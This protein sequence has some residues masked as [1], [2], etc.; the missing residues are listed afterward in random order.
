M[1]CT[2]CG[3]PLETN[4]RFCRN[5]GQLSPVMPMQEG[6]TES[7]PTN[8]ME[9]GQALPA[10]P[11]IFPQSQTPYYQPA[12][13][14]LQPTQPVTPGTMPSRAQDAL[15]R[16]LS[17]TGKTSR[18]G[19]GCITGCLV[20]LLVLVV[21]VGAGWVFALRPFLHSLAQA[22][23]DQTLTNAVNQIPAQAAQL[24]PGT[25]QVHENA[26]NNLIVLNSSPSDPVQQ[27]QVHIMPGGVRLNFQVYGFPCA[28][29]GVPQV[30]NGPL[31]GRLVITNVTVEG[32]VALIMS[33]GE[34]TNLANRHLAD[35]Q[36][37]FKH[38]IVQ[39][40]LKNH[41]LDLLVGPPL[42]LALP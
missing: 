31:N 29:T 20:T 4:A 17:T 25:V 32:I 38:P 15:P 34:V 3:R 7:S 22:Q 26:L 18:R 11:T 30:I 5:C 6:V 41:E 42:A 1:N 19:R 24:P 23:I 40:L 37:R 21:V 14:V 35:A 10:Q 9:P 13:P 36:A 33:P 39:V 16:T 28:V 12:Q 2:R 8:P 27:A